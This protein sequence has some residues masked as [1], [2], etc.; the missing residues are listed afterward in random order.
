MASQKNVVALE[1]TLEKQLVNDG[2]SA[3][4]GIDEA[5][6]GP[7][8]GPVVA[9]ACVLP[10]DVKIEGLNDSKK[11]KPDARLKLY[12]EIVEK[13]V[14]YS[15]A[16][17]SVEEIDALNILEATLLAMRRAA[18]KF[19][20][21]HKAVALEAYRSSVNM[22]KERGAF[23]IYDWERE[24][25]NP[26]INRIKDA[27]PALYEEMKQHPEKYKRYSTFQEALDEVFEDA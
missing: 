23:E 15:I 25:D 19:Y 20:K 27:D 17:A 4:C 14:D 2:F 16:Q 6:R 26:F 18:Q 24:K 9:A 21:L 8:C 3:V 5:G 7:L 22:A 12:N 11:L 13:A 1:F 10:I